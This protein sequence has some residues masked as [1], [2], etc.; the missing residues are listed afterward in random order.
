MDEIKSAR[1]LNLNYLKA[2]RKRT[3]PSGQGRRKGRVSMPSPTSTTCERGIA[4][5]GQGQG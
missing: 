3:V 1:G 5:G 4:R 2:T